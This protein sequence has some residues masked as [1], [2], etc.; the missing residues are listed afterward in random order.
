[1]KKRLTTFLIIL[2]VLMLAA[3]N[4]NGEEEVP[5][6]QRIIATTVA[7]TDTAAKLNIDLV[8]IPSTAKD[9]PE[10]YKEVKQIGQA[11]KPNMEIVRSLQPTDLLSVT[12]IKPEM[13]KALKSSG[14]KATY[15]NY[16]SIQGMQESIT[17]MGE[18]FDRVEEAKELNAVY[19]DKIEEIQTEIKDKKKPKVMILLG[20]PGSYLVSTEKSF[21]G[22][23]VE[24]AGG[25][26][27]IQATKSDEEFISS[28]TE[29]LYKL[30]PDVILRASHGF[31]SQV[32]AMFE[33]EFKTN[34]VWKNFKAT[35][36]GR[37]Y[38]LPEDIFGITANVNADES[39]QALY[40]LLYEEK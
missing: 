2:P 17:A 16:N 11:K 19:T 33:E 12:T 31:E 39:L 36:E 1:M 28:N 15:Y 3:C 4:A 18:K 30:Q 20:V 40:E 25:E 13:E 24:I 35:R 10:V 7:L 9:I 6:G 14:I 37:V 32:T 27:V 26:N 23:L 22:N 34:D 5:K 38:D 29:H 21:L 8:G